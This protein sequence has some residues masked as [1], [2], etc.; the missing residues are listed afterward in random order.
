MNK[1]LQIII[2]IGIIGAVIGAALIWKYEEH[3]TQEEKYYK[4]RNTNNTTTK[5]KA[6]IFVDGKMLAK[7]KNKVLRL[8]NSNDSTLNPLFQIKLDNSTQTLVI[9]DKISMNQD[10]QSLLNLTVKQLQ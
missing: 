8:S 7:D 3:L 1:K 5:Y 4:Q 2:F 9:D 6:N 10:V